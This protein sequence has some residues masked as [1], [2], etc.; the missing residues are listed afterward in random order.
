MFFGK[1]SNAELDEFA[2][3]LVSNIVAKLPPGTEPPTGQGKR[4]ER[5]LARSLNRVLD[6][7]RSWQRE[8]KLGVYGRAR[9]ANTFKWE[10]RDQ[11]YDDDFIEEATKALVLA[12][13]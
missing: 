1:S 4:A 8:K 11:G 9:V 2:K 13:N 5:N 3:E 12:L 7:A 6:S 10:L